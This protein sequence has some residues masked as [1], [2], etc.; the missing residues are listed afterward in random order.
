MTRM[1]ALRR[2]G[3]LKLLLLL[4]PG[5]P[6]GQMLIDRQKYSSLELRAD[7]YGDVC[8]YP[9]PQIC[10]TIISDRF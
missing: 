3:N 2:T 9:A 1:N 10:E 7:E 5:H 8:P 4:N 6:F